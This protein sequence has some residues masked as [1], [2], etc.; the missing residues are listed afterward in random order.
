MFLGNE[1]AIQWAIIFLLLSLNNSLV[2]QKNLRM[3]L[4]PKI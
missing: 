3:K 2:F 1:R 4:N